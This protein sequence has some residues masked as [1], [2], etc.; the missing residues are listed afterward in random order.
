MSDYLQEVKQTIFNDMI[1]KGII[2]KDGEILDKKQYIN[3]LN[4]ESRRIQAQI[5]SHK[6][7]GG[8]HINLLYKDLD[9]V[10]ELLAIT[11]PQQPSREDELIE[12]VKKN[13]IKRKQTIQNIK[14]GIKKFLL[15]FGFQ[16]HK[17]DTFERGNR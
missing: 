9:V 6:E 16:R 12:R 10:R 7:P 5:N 15:L 11:E 17:P 2:G 8:Q 3:Y 13:Q 4:R 1:Q 14:D